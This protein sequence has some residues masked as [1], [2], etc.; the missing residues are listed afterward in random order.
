ML[1]CYCSILQWNTADNVWL[2]YLNRAADNKRPTFPIMTVKCKLNSIPILYYGLNT[3]HLFPVCSKQIPCSQTCDKT[4]SHYVRQARLICRHFTSVKL[5]RSTKWQSHVG[6]HIVVFLDG[7]KGLVVENESVTF[8]WTGT[9]VKTQS[10]KL[11][12]CLLHED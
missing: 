5:N 10:S 7:R 6:I 11:Q 2:V 8:L 3:R 12:L 1:P 4:Q 9:E